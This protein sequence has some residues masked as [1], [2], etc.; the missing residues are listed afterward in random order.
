MKLIKHRALSLIF[1]LFLISSLMIFTQEAI[2][3]FLKPLRSAENSLI[4]C[5]LAKPITQGSSRV[6]SLF[7]VANDITPPVISDV[8][9]TGISA[10]SA[11]ITWTT[12]ED[13]TSVVNYGTNPAL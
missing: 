12:D 4:E 7:S 9:A 6:H 8:Q 5:P 13:S 10:T 3:L 11:T 1:A 2:Y